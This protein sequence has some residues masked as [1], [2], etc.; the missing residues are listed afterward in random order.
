MYK[1][2]EFGNYFESKIKD[3]DDKHPTHH[4]IINDGK[5]RKE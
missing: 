4:G 2:D 1:V 5:V 3:K